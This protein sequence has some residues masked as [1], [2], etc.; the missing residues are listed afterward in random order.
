MTD[1]DELRQAIIAT[2]P[3]GKLKEKYQLSPGTIMT[4]FKLMTTKSSTQPRM[5]R[6]YIRYRMG[7]AL[8]AMNQDEAS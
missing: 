2:T 1:E 6:D 8:Q 3:K 4:E 5:I 7:L